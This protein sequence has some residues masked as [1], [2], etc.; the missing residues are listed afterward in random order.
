MRL[1]SSPRYARAAAL[2]FGTIEARVCDVI[3]PIKER[4]R[5]QRELSKLE[6]DLQVVSRK[7]ANQGFVAR[8]PK[9]VVD[10]EHKRHATLSAKKTQLEEAAAKLA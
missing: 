7:L 6:K 1:E 2:S 5:L 8:A 10:A 4:E 9:E 3:D